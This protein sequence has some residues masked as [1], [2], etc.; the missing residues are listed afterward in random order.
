MPFAL[1]PLPGSSNVITDASDFDALSDA[2]RVEHH[3]LWDYNSTSI[4]YIHAHDTPLDKWLSVLGA[5]ADPELDP[6]HPCL[7]HHL[8]ESL[9]LRAFKPAPEVLRKHVGEFI[10]APHRLGEALLRLVEAGIDL[11]LSPSVTPANALTT[12]LMRVNA[13]LA[14]AFDLLPLR[15]IDLIPTVSSP[16]PDNLSSQWPSRVM[17]GDLVQPADG[18]L[19][20]AADLVGLL[21]FRLHFSDREDLTSQYFVVANSLVAPQ[22]TGPM[23]SLG[24]DSKPA[25]LAA[26][27]VTTAWP[28]ALAVAP[29]SFLSA[30]SDVADRLSYGTPGS[31][32]IRK[33]F[34]TVLLHM[35]SLPDFVAGTPA[36][37]AFQLAVGLAD[38]LLDV[39]DNSS[40]AALFALDSNLKGK[41]GLL[42]VHDARAKSAQERCALLLAHKDTQDEANDTP[43]A[44]SD[45]SGGSLASSASGVA[46][47]YT[48]ELGLFLLSPAVTGQL[49]VVPNRTAADGTSQYDEQTSG[50]L[51]LLDTATS[52][53]NRLRLLFARR[54]VFV[55]QALLSNFHHPDPLFKTLAEAR[56]HLN[57]YLSM[58]VVTED[59]GSVKPHDYTFELDESFIKDLLAGK[60]DSL[61]FHKQLLVR[62]HAHRSRS[63][64]PKVVPKNMQWLTATASA[65]GKM[66]A[67]LFS[68]LA[69]ARHDAQH[70]FSELVDTVIAYIAA[71]PMG[72]DHTVL[73]LKVI[74]SALRFASRRWVLWTKSPPGAKAPSSFLEE[75]DHCFEMLTDAYKAQDDLFALSNAYPSLV[76]QLA[77]ESAS[78]NGNGGGSGS[79]RG[80]GGGGSGG[81]SPATKPPS[82]KKQKSAPTSSSSRPNSSS[83][84]NSK[85][86]ASA[87][88]SPPAR[89]PS[90]AGDKPVIAP[91]SLAEKCTWSGRNLKFERHYYDAQTKSY[92]AL[93]PDT[94]DIG[95]FC[96]A[97]GTDFNAYCW[98]Y[99]ATMLLQSLANNN[100]PQHCKNLAAARCKNFGAGDHPDAATGKHAMPPQIAQLKNFFRRG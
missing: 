76:G 98:P 50:L 46:L 13:V 35:Q 45:S 74:D 15:N 84:P 33:R 67:R 100:H 60:W 7:D 83:N 19:A 95:G 68:G 10:V 72:V 49:V 30:V 64:A 43:T 51:A 16:T 5:I 28:A 38:N 87:S 12:L 31:T 47:R 77:R 54:N 14:G 69:Y 41:V 97:T 29:S 40:L 75:G 71:A 18:S 20:P 86:A 44:S 4:L 6:A 8:V 34:D 78:S 37:Q 22:L 39:T 17:F 94:V 9:L 91:K 25:L 55:T 48:R 63:L 36:S 56:P 65:T 73:G 58:C 24:D 27:M 81:G 82:T 32:V 96:Q 1:R 92:V 90:G 59:D 3:D 57:K 99:V 52:D 85:P 70:G 21:G 88:S 42:D 61:D 2:G 23:E 89:Q 26:H 93:P 11:E 66:A 62:L 53:V 79:G 80:G